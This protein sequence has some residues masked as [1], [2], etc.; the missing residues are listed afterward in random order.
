YRVVKD[1]KVTNKIE[2][3]SADKE[4][5]KIIAQANQ[6]LKEDGTF[7]SDFALVRG[8]D[9]EADDVP[10]K[11]VQY[12]DVSPRQMVSIGTSLI[13]FLEHDD[14]NRALMGANMQ[15]QAVPVINPEAPR[16]GTG[17]EMQV[18]KDSGDVL[19]APVDGTV[20]EF[21]DNSVIFE[22]KDNKEI[23]LNLT[24]FARTNQTTCNNHKIVANVGDKLK[25]GDV[26][27]DGSSSE[28]GELA[29]GKNL[30]VAFMSW[31]GYN[32]EDAI[33]L[34]ERIVNDDELTSIHIEKYEVECRKTKLG[35]EQITDDLPD[36]SEA[37]K[38]NL[39][40]EGLIRVGAEVKERDILVGKV[41]PRGDTSSSPEEKL[42]QAI[43]GDEKPMRNSS[44]K[45]PNGG[46]G[47]VTDVQVFES[48]D[49]KNN[50]VI[51]TVRVLVAQKRK[52]TVGD[53][54]S[55][56]HGNKGVISKILPIEDMPYLEDGT[57]VDV[58]LNPMGVPGRMNVGQVLEVHLGWLTKRG[59][60]INLAKGKENDA[61]KSQVPA[62]LAE[63]AP[64]AKVATP[65]FDGVSSDVVMGLFKAQNVDPDY[66]PLV[67]ETG[68]AVLYDGRSGEKF[69]MPISVGYMY[70][71]KLHHL[72][73]DK[74][75]ARSTGPY[76][77]VT[78]QPLGGKAQFGGQRFGEMEVWAL[79][80]YGSAYSLHEMMTIK[81]DD[82]IGRNN[83]YTS[84]LK[85]L[86]ISN[87]G[88]PESFKVLVKEMRSLGLNV[89]L[90]DK[91]DKTLN[92]D[93]ISGS[94]EIMTRAIKK[95]RPQIRPNANFSGENNADEGFSEI[96][97]AE[98][99]SADED[100]SFSVDE[101]AAQ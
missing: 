61:W 31:E 94:T 87:D 11:Q 77:I 32:Y 27:A 73:D 38:A 68:K 72:V 17:V 34:S 59:W 70:I 100:N 20:K 41:T 9:G 101:I 58:I 96:I 18:A 81:S 64:G 46:G 86:P 21:K 52:I 8:T 76:S 57:P 28:G 92:I 42:Y 29:I 15:R 30:M 37:A 35:D 74:M 40:S 6:E 12:M 82:I 75:H 49:P 66:G 25:K 55:G 60:N 13:P 79:Q 69:P 97:K 3:L 19:L 65:V 51:K 91:N 80:G 1:G 33:I 4:F 48:D 50:D 16:V 53:K 39:D 67:Q 78:Q 10:V 5:G 88:T 62:E 47:I 89:T 43:F 85:G 2:Y 36:V 63:V 26:I 93:E 98:G 44:L 54:L 83:L 71:L 84:I 45:V 24:K 7:I 95:D 23:E 22:D 56:R 90:L 99:S 14:A